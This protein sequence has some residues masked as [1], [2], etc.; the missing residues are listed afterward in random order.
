MNTRYLRLVS[1]ALV[2]SLPHIALADIAWP[3]LFLEQRLLAWYS[4]A[5]GLLGEWL[6][7]R[8]G[9]RQAWL[10]AAGMTLLMNL[11]STLAGIILQPLLG[12][13]WEFFPARL[14]YSLLGGT[15]NPVTWA[16]T[17]VIAVVASVVIELLVLVR[18]FELEVS[19]HSVLVLVGAN[20]FSVAIA[21]GSLFLIPLS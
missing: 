16:A 21:F 7:V 14:L 20:T 11:F 3:A 5:I 9:L 18:F 13:A 10:R 8:F 19:R 4:I 6:F 15:F 1:I 2:L 12:L 17:F